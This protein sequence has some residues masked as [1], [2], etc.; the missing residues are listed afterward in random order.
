MKHFLLAGKDISG[1]LRILPIYIAQHCP[2][3]NDVRNCAAYT[4]SNSI[5]IGT[6]WKLCKFSKVFWQQNHSDLISQSTE[7]CTKAMVPGEQYFQE[8]KISKSAKA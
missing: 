8:P 1:M 6:V 2:C 5:V 7:L 3:S 4:S